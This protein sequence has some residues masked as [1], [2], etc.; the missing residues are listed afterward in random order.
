MIKFRKEGRREKEGR[1]IKAF[2]DFR[3]IIISR[4]RP[5]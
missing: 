5:K 4:T 1:S 2:K 3:I